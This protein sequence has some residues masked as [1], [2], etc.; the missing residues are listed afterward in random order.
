MKN[1][2]KIPYLL[3]AMA[4]LFITAGCALTQ[5][6][7]QI[8]PLKITGGEEILV[9]KD[10][11]SSPFWCGDKPILVYQLTEGGIYYYDLTTRKSTKI[12]LPY[13]NAL[14]C[15]HDGK[16]LIYWDSLSSR[17]DVGAKDKFV[18][19][20]WRYEFE[21][22]R[23]EK[24]IIVDIYDTRATIIRPNNG[25]LYLGRE[26][27]LSIAMPEPKWAITRDPRN[28]GMRIWLKDGSLAFGSHIDFSQPQEDRKRIVDIEVFHPTRKS[29]NFTP[30]FDDFQ[31]LFTD[32][33][34]RLYLKVT[35][36]QNTAD[37]YS[38]LNRCRIN[39]KKESLS[40]ETIFSPW[41][42]MWGIDTFSDGENII[43]SKSKEKCVKAVMIGK[44]NSHCIT[45]KHLIGGTIRISP[46]E[47]WVAFKKIREHEDREQISDQYILQINKKRSLNNGNTK[48]HK[49][50]RHNWNQQY[51]WHANTPYYRS[52]EISLWH[53]LYSKHRRNRDQS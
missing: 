20:L 42:E 37:Y 43:L 21:T 19:D 47:K 34:G 10:A 40:C 26:P 28:S 33:L 27:N 6:T 48:F 12:A 16:W 52:T 1:P 53:R 32:N 29:F 18:M 3:A 7:K 45:K 23:N 30:E 11:S 9:A 5:K 46:D 24:F 8:K 14:T 2:L 25:K 13:S 15:T 50:Y 35:Q 39:T 31:L 49:T 22:G 38:Y 51:L 41:S 36:E 4:F 17:D 44:N